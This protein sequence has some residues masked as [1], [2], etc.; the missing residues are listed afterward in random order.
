MRN[1]SQGVFDHFKDIENF[2]VVFALNFFEDV[3]LVKIDNCIVV[4]FLMK[5]VSLNI[6]RVSI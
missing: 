4:P 5:Y 6:H 2:V 3:S 1:G